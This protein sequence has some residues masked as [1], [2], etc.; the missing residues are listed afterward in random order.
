VLRRLD[1]PGSPAAGGLAA[2]TGL[3]VN[4]LAALVWVANPYAAALLLPA[5]H[6]WLL[7]AAPESRL[8]GAPGA[9]AVAAGLLAPLLVVVHYM[10]ALGLDPAAF[11]WFS[12]L[13]TAGGHVSLPGALAAG[14][15]LGCLAGLLT[16]MRTR[17]R[18]AAAAPPETLRTRGPAGYA[19]PGSLGGTESALRR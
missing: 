19:G 13:I 1:V 10:R 2:A 15:W 3:I 12:A 5:A 6:L 7:A 17:R 14:L 18:V 16:V 4:L 11:A 8:R 9:V